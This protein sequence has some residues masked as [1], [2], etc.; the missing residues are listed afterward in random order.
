MSGSEDFSRIR[1]L[2]RTS[3]L[4]NASCASSQRGVA[5]LQIFS[6]LRCRGTKTLNA[7]NVSAA[8]EV[9]MIVRNMQV[10]LISE[11]MLNQLQQKGNRECLR[12][13][14]CTTAEFKSSLDAEQDIPCEKGVAGLRRRA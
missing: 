7:I 6:V 13:R 2:E 4:S 9:F 1:T 5:D 12:R 14:L 11:P 10:L 8:Y 3:L